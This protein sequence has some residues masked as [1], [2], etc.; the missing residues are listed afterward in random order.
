MRNR[1]PDRDGQKQREREGRGEGEGEKV[2][3]WL[4]N[5]Q[6]TSK[7][8]SGTDPAETIVCAAPLRQKLQFKLSIPPKHSILTS[9]QPVPALTCHARCLTG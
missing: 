9:G 8:T 2:V 4:H 3:C 7:C 5:V 1:K 6:A